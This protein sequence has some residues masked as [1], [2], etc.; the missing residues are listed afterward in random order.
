MHAFKPHS[1]QIIPA[2]AHRT[3]CSWTLFNWEKY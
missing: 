3:A 2:V 1:K